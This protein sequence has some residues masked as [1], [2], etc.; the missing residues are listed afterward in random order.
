MGRSKQAPL[1]TL[2]EVIKWHAEETLVGLSISKVT[3]KLWPH[4]Y[5]IQVK[6]SQVSVEQA[7]RYCI[8]KSNLFRR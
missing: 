7:R 5:E 4:L 8:P 1:C 2:V 3:G 6:P